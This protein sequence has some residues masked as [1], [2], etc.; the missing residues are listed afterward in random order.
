M[1][2]LLYVDYV[3]GVNMSIRTAN[4]LPQAYPL[5]VLEQKLRFWLLIRSCCNVDYFSQVPCLYQ[6]VYLGLNKLVKYSPLYLV[7]YGAC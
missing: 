1:L 7:T 2:F 3:G 5:L 4:K 6:S